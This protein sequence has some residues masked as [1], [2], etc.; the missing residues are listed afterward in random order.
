MSLNFHTTG[1]IQVWDGERHCIDDTEPRKASKKS[2]SECHCVYVWTSDSTANNRDR[3]RSRSRDRCKTERKNDHLLPRDKTQ[4]LYSGTQLL[5]PASLQAGSRTCR[6]RYTG[7]DIVVR[8]ANQAMQLLPVSIVSYT[9]DKPDPMFALGLDA[10]LETGMLHFRQ[11]V[12][13]VALVLRER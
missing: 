7:M 12:L 13:E 3:G 8:L 1:L 10:A 2:D 9:Q 11:K 5:I 6:H 4:N